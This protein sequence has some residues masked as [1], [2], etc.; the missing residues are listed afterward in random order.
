[1]LRWRHSLDPDRPRYAE[2]GAIPGRLDRGP[3]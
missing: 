2:I 1:L 3:R